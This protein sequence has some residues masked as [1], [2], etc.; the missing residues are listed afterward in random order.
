MSIILWID[1]W[2]TTTWFAIL[3]KQGKNVEILSCWIIETKAKESLDLKLFDIWKDIEFIL[4]KYKPNICCIEKI[5]FLKNVKTWIDVAHARGVMIY[6]ISKKWIPIKEY[7]PLQVK[8]GICGNWKA[9]KKQV[10]KALKCILKLDS[11][12]TPDDAADALA[13]AYLW[14]LEK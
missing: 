4:K 13:I 7:T 2:T 14:S 1:P 5:F 11:I 10:Q 8:Q 3:D 6:L 12:P 9:D